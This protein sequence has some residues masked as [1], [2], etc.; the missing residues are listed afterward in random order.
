MTNQTTK[1]RKWRQY[2]ATF[3][4][5]TFKHLQKIAYMKHCSI[6]NLLSIIAEDYIDTHTDLIE[7]YDQTV[8]EECD[9]KPW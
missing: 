9:T 2:S 6:N 8:T 3:R 7:A 1:E 5:S 4:P